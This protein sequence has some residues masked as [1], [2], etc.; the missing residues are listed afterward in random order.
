MN[1]KFARYCWNV[2]P[3]ASR[4][5]SQTL[6]MGPTRRWGVGP[7]K[8]ALSCPPASGEKRT[9][10]KIPNPPTNQKSRL[11]PPP[12]PIAAGRSRYRI[13]GLLRGGYFNLIQNGSE[14]FPQE[15]R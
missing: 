14:D 1:A 8:T 5:V 6:S 3:D 10:S 12:S 13:G 7:V 15:N 4:S 9:A 2:T 11:S